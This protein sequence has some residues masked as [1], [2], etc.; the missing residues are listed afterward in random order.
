MKRRPD[1]IFATPAGTSPQKR[2]VY[3]A[4]TAQPMRS[5]FA[6]TGLVPVQDAFG[7]LA[8]GEP[9]HWTYYEQAPRTAHIRRTHF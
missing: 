6:H 2:S 1:E 7:R 5:L 4:E 3:C 8:A 9:L